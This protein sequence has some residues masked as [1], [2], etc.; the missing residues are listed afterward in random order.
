MLF[1]IHGLVAQFI[2]DTEVS[3]KWIA[4]TPPKRQVEGSNPSGPVMYS[5]SYTCIR[6]TIRQRRCKKVLQCDSTTVKKM[7]DII[8]YKEYREIFWRFFEFVKK[9]GTSERY[10]NNNLKAIIASVNFSDTKYP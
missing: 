1:K 8:T 7:E 4:R 3:A 2:S 5:V 6:N 10:Q 9:I